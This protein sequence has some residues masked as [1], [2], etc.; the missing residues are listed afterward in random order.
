VKR[1]SG[2]YAAKDLDKK[3]CKSEEDPESTKEIGDV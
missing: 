3:E 1:T 2:G